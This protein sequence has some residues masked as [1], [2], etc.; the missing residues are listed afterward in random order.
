MRKKIKRWKQ[1]KAVS[2]GKQVAA[3]RI[4]GTAVKL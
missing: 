1:N 2:S 4:S 3:D